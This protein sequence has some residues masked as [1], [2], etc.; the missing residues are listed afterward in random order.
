MLEILG[1]IIFKNQKSTVAPPGLKREAPKQ[2]SLR[3]AS[4]MQG[5]SFVERS[6][7]FCRLEKIKKINL[8]SSS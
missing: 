5:A 1:Y 3:C 4:L 6:P 2:A 8:I 7:L